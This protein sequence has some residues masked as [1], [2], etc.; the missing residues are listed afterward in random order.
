MLKKYVAI[1]LIG[2]CLLIC[3]SSCSDSAQSPAQ[4]DRTVQKSI[5]TS[6]PKPTPSPTP[7]T[8]VAKPIHISIPAIKVDADIEPVGIL[9]S[10]NLDTPHRNPWDSTGWF[11]NGALPGNTGSAVIDGHVDRPGGGPAVFWNLQYMKAGDE[12]I[13]TTK[14]DQVLHFHVTKRMAYPPSE[15]PMQTIFGN[16]SGKYLNLI[17][18]AGDW[19]PSEQQTS[20]R[21]VVFASLETN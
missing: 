5:P 20:L 2:M 4:T 16:D 14:A 11:D 3:M 18:C 17:T 10:G 9:T 1:G 6:T 13:V 8:I 15:A 7:A 21:M 19:I 12:I